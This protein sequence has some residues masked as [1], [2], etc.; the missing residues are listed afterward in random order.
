MVIKILSLVDS[1]TL[2]NLS[3]VSTQWKEYTESN[4]IWKLNVQK[5]QFPVSILPSGYGSASVDKIGTIQNPN[6]KN[7]FRLEESSLV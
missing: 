1:D 2:G 4:Q 6:W 7:L 5:A 3:N